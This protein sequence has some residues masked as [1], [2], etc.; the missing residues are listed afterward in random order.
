MGIEQDI[1]IVSGIPYKNNGDIFKPLTRLNMKNLEEG[2][3]E[4]LFKLLKKLFEKV[5]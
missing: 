3:P 2:A 1:A 5:I 4:E